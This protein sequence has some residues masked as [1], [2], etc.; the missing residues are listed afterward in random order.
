VFPDATPF[1]SVVMLASS[2]AAALGVP[3]GLCPAQRVTWETPF[4]VLPGLAARTRIT[5]WKVLPHVRGHLTD[6]P[7]SR[8]RAFLDLVRDRNAARALLFIGTLV[9][10]HFSIIPLLSPYLVAN[11]GLPESRLFLVY[12]V[13]GVVTTFSSPLVG[14]LADRMGHLRVYAVLVIVACGVTLL[15]SNSGPRPTWYI[16]VLSGLFFVF[17][18]GRFVP[19]QA[20]LTMA[21]LSRRSQLIG[22]GQRAMDPGL[23]AV[24]FNDTRTQMNQFRKRR[25]L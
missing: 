15:L 9:V 3:V 14:R 18:S 6:E 4:L 10:G 20:M 13:G 17:A 8:V 5:A 24:D 22:G 12:L 21:D 7:I 19:A 1:R 2:V 16:L 23:A 25:R 11:V